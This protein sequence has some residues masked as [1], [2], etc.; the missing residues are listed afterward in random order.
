MPAIPA[1]SKLV[2][3]NSYFVTLRSWLLSRI[4]SSNKSKS[5]NASSRRKS[6]PGSKD[7]TDYAPYVELIDSKMAHIG[8]RPATKTHIQHVTGTELPSNSGINMSVDM[9]VSSMQN[10]PRE[11]I[12]HFGRWNIGAENKVSLCATPRIYTLQ[13]V[14]YHILW[15]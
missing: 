13:I 6:F 2:T 1:I 7:P 4:S 15:E 3:A 14:L 10:T 8:N 12:R 5:S 9:E 11:W